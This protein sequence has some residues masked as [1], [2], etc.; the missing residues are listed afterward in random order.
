MNS[1]VLAETP[2][3]KQLESNS[4]KCVGT[5]GEGEGKVL[6]TWWTHSEDFSWCDV[7]NITSE[8]DMDRLSRFKLLLTASI[9]W[10][11]FFCLLSSHTKSVWADYMHT[12]W[13]THTYHPMNTFHT[14]EP[15][16][17]ET[18]D[19]ELLRRLEPSRMTKQGVTTLNSVTN[20][21]TFICFTSFLTFAA[22]IC[23]YVNVRFCSLRLL[24]ESSG[25][26]RTEMS[27]LCFDV[28]HGV[29]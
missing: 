23:C 13:K 29:I 19:H 7:W 15:A 14:C 17:V 12:S 18:L 2:T 20:S 8:E 27:M 5:G 24:T 28:L 4:N 9:R 16:A 21:V 26:R 6:L 11:R 1:F 3:G 25:W 22:V 10:R